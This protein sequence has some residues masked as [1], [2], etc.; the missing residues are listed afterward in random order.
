MS[1]QIEDA[2]A[3][4][5]AKANETTGTDVA[6]TSE[7]GALAP[8]NAGV[9]MSLT[10]FLQSGGLS[11]DKWIAVKDTGF[12]LD[13]NDKAVLQ[14]VEVDI[15]FS[16]VKL[17]QGL[18]IS[19]PGNKYEYIKTYDGRTES[20]TGQAWTVAMAEANGRSTQPQNPYRG[21]DIL[22]TNV[23]DVT[24]GKT[25]IEAGTKLGYT[26]SIT[27]FG[28]FQSFLASL[29]NAGK[30]QVGPDGVTLSGVVR[31][32]VTHEAKSNADYEWGVLNFEEA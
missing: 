3:A 22:M 17:F 30:V 23:E 8:A 15:D 29:I 20:R 21:A 14:E 31:T 28:G 19:L 12:K 24:Q 13:K 1:T 5:E 27:G 6:T 11:P 10:S 7:G 25:T 9:D 4:A 18:R 16:N 32:K 26:T 2:I